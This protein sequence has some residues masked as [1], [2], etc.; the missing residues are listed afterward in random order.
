MCLIDHTNY[1]HL[2]MK[3]KLFKL[4]EPFYWGTSVMYANGKDGRHRRYQY[5]KPLSH[6]S[7][8]QYYSDFQEI[9]NELEKKWS[10]LVKEEQIPLWQYMS[11]FALKVVFRAM[12]GFK[13]DKEVLEFRRNYDTCWDD[14]E[15][16][17]T[18]PI[19]PGSQ[20]QKK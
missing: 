1:N 19:Q 15:R 20:R 3:T 14:L 2:L 16:S 6:E 13:D 4:F 8:K 9:A 12:F 5:D 11:D 7:L 17:L 10:T 18:K